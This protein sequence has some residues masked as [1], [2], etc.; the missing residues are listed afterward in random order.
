M[1]RRGTLLLIT[2]MLLSLGT[3]L[4]SAQDRIHGYLNE[5][6]LQVR[7]TPGVLHKREILSTRLG[8]LTRALAAARNMPLTSAGDAA[9]LA[10]I[11]DTLHER[12]D[13]L[14]GVNGF[15]R[16]PDDQL[17]AFA[18]YIVQDME[19]AD[20]TVSMSLVTLLLIIIIVILIA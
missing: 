16:V 20:R 12:S 19:Q 5:T 9:N 3:G 18:S 11:A 4:A 8:Q 1:T 15:E 2:A 7:A 10:R 17:D 6:A 13:E 14:A